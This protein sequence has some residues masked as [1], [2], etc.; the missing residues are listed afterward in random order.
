MP[1]VAHVLFFL[2]LA[3]AIVVMATFYGEPEDGPAFR[4]IPRRYGVFCFSCL[5]VAAA[6]LLCERLFASV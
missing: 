4:A 3:A 1:L 6:M 5:M 2:A